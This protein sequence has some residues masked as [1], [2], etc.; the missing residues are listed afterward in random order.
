MMVC[1]ICE[2]ADVVAIKPGTCAE[3]TLYPGDP[4]VPCGVA[5]PSIGWCGEHWLLGW[6]RVPTTKGDQ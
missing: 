2:S 3:A 5:I 1:T 6:V 4:A